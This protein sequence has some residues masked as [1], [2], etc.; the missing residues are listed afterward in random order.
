[1][2]GMAPTATKADEAA[3]RAYMVELHQQLL[4][5]ARADNSYAASC[6]RTHRNKS[7][8]QPRRKRC[9]RR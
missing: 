5:L 1:M 2:Q 6:S 3:L 7:A 8:S 9:S 4:D